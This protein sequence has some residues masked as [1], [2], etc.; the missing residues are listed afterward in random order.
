MLYEVITQTIYFN[1]AVVIPENKYKYDALYRLLEATGREHV[2]NVAH[3][4]LDFANN[5][6]L[7]NDG[8]AMQNY[9]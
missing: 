9:T 8:S 1:N 7:P 2:S 4:Y 3:S 6:P 5:V